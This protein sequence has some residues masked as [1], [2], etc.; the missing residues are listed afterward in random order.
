MPQRVV[1]R[2]LGV[3]ALGPAGLVE[4]LEQPFGVARGEP[5]G[6]LRQGSIAAAHAKLR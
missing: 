3:A 6:R 4:Q 1:E 5:G 2:A